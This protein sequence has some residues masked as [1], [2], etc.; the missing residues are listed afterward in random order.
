MPSFALRAAV[1][2]LSDYLLTGRRAIP[3]ALDQL[4]FRF[5][6]P[7]LDEAVRSALAA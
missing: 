3:H 7:A 5:T 4:G 1:G 2:E 6:H